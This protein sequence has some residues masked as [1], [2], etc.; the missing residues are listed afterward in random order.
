MSNKNKNKSGVVYSTN[1][2]FNPSENED[3][4]GTSTPPNQQQLRVWRDNKSRAGKTVTIVKGFVGEEQEL[5]D[6]GRILKSK[7][8]VGGTV[9]DGEI[10]I[11]G[12]FRDRVTDLLKNLGY[13]VKAAGG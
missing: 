9:K 1:P 13:G 11:Q 7:C 12:D 8:G 4:S 10:L 2:N 3:A 5:E 6:L